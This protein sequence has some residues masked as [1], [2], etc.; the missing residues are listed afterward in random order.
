M[1]H[2]SIKAEQIFS[3]FGFPIMNS[4]LLSWV[5]LLVFILIGRYYA[6][7]LHRKKKSTLFYVFHTFFVGIRGLVASILHEKSAIFF[8]LL[9]AYFFFILLNN[10]FG[11]L[12]GVGSLLVQP[13]TSHEAVVLKPSPDGFDAEPPTYELHIDPSI[14]LFRANAA[15]LNTTLALALITVF[16]IQYYGIKY[17][18]LRGYM[19]KFV[20]FSS[21]IK[22][23][24]G[25]LELISE[26]SRILSFSFRL[27]G[28]ILAGEILITIVAFLLPSYVSFLLLPFFTL[29]ILAGFIQAFVFTMISTVLIGMATQKAAH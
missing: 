25:I 13:L 8:P 4:M 1:P 27:F 28:N 21:P 29:E 6:S 16:L 9:G 11:L 24:V 15:D 23:F 18:G 26:F 19:K 14:P 10:W 5:V 7:Q 20:D 12:P 17:N 2:I 3:I 22:F